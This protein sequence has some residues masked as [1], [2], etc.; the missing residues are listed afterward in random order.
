M[1]SSQFPSRHWRLRA[2]C[3]SFDAE[4]FFAQPDESQGER[5]RRERDAARVCARCMV[6]EACR[7]DALSTG[8]IHGVWGGLTERERGAPLAGR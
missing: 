2:K 5:I 8:E 7:F 6:R 3:S 1:P 4:I